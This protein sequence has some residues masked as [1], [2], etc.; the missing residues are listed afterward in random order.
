MFRSFFRVRTTLRSS[1]P[2]LS[3][4]TDEENPDACVED[5]PL[6]FSVFRRMFVSSY[7][8][9]MME[10]P[11]IDFP[12]VTGSLLPDSVKDIISRALRL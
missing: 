1:A 7:F 9:R 5:F 4:F 10:C 2:A 6:V 12:D 8:I 11:L 3:A